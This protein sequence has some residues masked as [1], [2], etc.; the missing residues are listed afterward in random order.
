MDD[1][2]GS[3]L[4]LTDS[5]GL[6]LG[7]DILPRGWTSSLGDMEAAGGDAVA[8]TQRILGLLCR[9]MEVPL[10]GGLPRRPKTLRVN[11]KKLHRLELQYTGEKIL[12]FL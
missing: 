4:L 10:S 12:F 8:T 3:V 2:G 9:S 5:S 7:F 11:D 6:P 1:D